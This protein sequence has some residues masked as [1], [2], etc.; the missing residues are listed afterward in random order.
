MPLSRRGLYSR[1][2]AAGQAGHRAEVVAHQVQRHRLVALAAAAVLGTL[3]EE[4]GE[5]A[6]AGGRLTGAC[7]GQMRGHGGTA[8]AAAHVYT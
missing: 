8:S 3:E 5:L 6:A 2:I 4:L 1:G 7:G